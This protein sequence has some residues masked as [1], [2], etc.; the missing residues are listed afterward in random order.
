M[1]LRHLRSWAI[2]V[3]PVVLHI[4]EQN[5]NALLHVLLEAW[6]SEP[7]LLLVIWVDD[8]VEL[9]QLWQ[10]ALGWRL[11]HNILSGI[12]DIWTVEVL[13]NWRSHLL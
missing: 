4:G 9:A 1:G 10:H 12:Q 11:G 3:L 13:R 5:G 8:F 2:H 6:N 7:P